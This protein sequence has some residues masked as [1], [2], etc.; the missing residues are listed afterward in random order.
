[1]ESRLR[2]LLPA[3]PPIAV[4]VEPI[5]DHRDALLPEELPAIGRAIDKR[6]DEFSTGR[7]AARRAMRALGLSAGAVGRSETRA[8]AWPLHSIGSITHAGDTAMALVARRETVRG[9]GI[10]LEES[11]RVTDE[12]FGKLFTGREQ[13]ALRSAGGSIEVVHRLGALYFSAKEAVYKA[14]NPLVGRFI[15][16]QEV[17]IDLTH[18]PTAEQG[19]FRMRYVGDHEPNRIMELGEGYYDFVDRYVVTVFLIR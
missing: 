19:G 8:P 5:A 4:A 15:G 2:A 10:D 6:I 11:H 7:V 3:A 14:V 12:L 1:M 16:F 13:A 17:E 9:I 18:A